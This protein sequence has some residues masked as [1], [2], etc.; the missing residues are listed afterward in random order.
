MPEWSIVLANQFTCMPAGMSTIMQFSL[1]S[2]FYLDI[3]NINLAKLTWIIS[4]LPIFYLHFKCFYAIGIFFN[5]SGKMFQVLSPGNDILFKSWYKFYVRI[6]EWIID[7][8]PNLTDCTNQ[9]MF[10]FQNIRVKRFLLNTNSFIWLH[11]VWFRAKYAC[12]WR[13]QWL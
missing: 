7:S 8:L 13:N 1:T 4:K 5:P 11:F 6:I 12:S 9:V 10:G 3:L 2:L